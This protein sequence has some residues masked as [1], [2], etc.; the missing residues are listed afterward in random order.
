MSLF[1]FLKRARHFKEIWAWEGGAKVGGGEC[2]TL[3]IDFFL[4]PQMY[5]I[6]ADQNLIKK[7]LKV[8]GCR[9]I[10]HSTPQF[11]H[12]SDCQATKLLLHSTGK[13]VNC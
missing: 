6:S 11:K 1:K 9:D 12:P 5:L 7:V 13:I 2:S 4:H 8:C 10:C 3:E